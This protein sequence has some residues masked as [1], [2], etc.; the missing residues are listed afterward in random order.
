MKEN[1]GQLELALK[2][3]KQPKGRLDILLK[4]IKA[5]SDKDIVRC[6]AWA[7]EAIELAEELGGRL[8]L[9]RS[10]E[11]LGMALWKL[12]EYTASMEKY[13]LALDAFLALGDHYGMAKCYIGK[14][15]ICGTL[16]EYK[17]AILNRPWQQ[18]KRLGAR[19]F[20]PP[21]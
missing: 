12:A 7:N 13:D 9:A 19:N 8:A 14:G 5:L 20:R 15:I 10:R 6:E 21:L 11:G 3:A 16:T 17:T 18:V 4:L 2:E 1:I